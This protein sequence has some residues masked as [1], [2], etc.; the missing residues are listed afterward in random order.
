LE[1]VQK[2]WVGT[3]L[4][5]VIEEISPDSSRVT[6]THQGLIPEFVCYDFCSTAWVHFIGERLKSYPE[7]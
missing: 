6:F 7:A 2:E 5:W 1:D 4:H 3:Q